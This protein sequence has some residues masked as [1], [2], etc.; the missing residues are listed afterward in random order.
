MADKAQSTDV[1][2]AVLIV[3]AGIGGMG[4]AMLLAEMGYK[5]YLLDRAPGIGGSMHLLDRTFPTDSCGLC[6]MAPVQ[7]AYCPTLECDLHPHIEILPYADLERLEGEPGAFQATIHHWPRYVDVERCNRCGQC[8][9]VCPV[10]RPSEYEEELHLEKAIYRPPSRAVPDAFVIDKTY[11]TECGRCVEVCPTEAIDLNNERSLLEGRR[12]QIEV[13]AVILSPGFTPFDARLKGE[14]GYGLY[15]NVLTSIQFERMISPAGYTQAHIVRP[16]DGTPP[17]RMAFIQCVG[18]RDNRRPEAGRLCGQ[19]YCSAVCCMYTAKQVGVAKELRPDL[20]ITVFYIDIRTFG[21]DFERYFN[22][23]AALPGVTYRR[24]MV[25]SVKQLVGSG[26]LRLTYVAE[27][28]NLRE[29]DFDMVVLAVG[30]APPTG[31][32]ELGRHLGVELNEYGFCLAHSF[33]PNHTS[34]PGVFVGGSFR[35][36]KDIPETVIEAAGAS[37]SA[38]RFLSARDGR[39]LRPPAPEEKKEQDVSEEEPRIGVFVCACGQ[40]ADQV[41]DV[42]AVAAQAQ[43]LPGVAFSRVVA[44]ACEPEGLKQIEMAIKESELNRVVVAACSPRLYR[45][46]FE[47]VM[48]EA[49]LNPYLLERVNIREQCAWVHQEDHKAATVKAEDLVAMAV[50]T[51]GFNRALQPAHITPTRS[52][53]VIGGGLAGMTAALHLAEQGCHVHLVEREAEL[54]GT[55]RRVRYVLEGERTDTFLQNL[56]AQVEGSELISVYKRAEVQEVKGYKGQYQSVVALADGEIKQL[57]HGAII[58][59]TGGQE[60]KTEEY[61][62]GREPRVVTQLELE[63]M[64]SAS[65]E[66]QTKIDSLRSVVMIQ[67]VGSRDEERPYCSRV[68]CSQAIKNALKIKELNPQVNVFILHRDVCTYGFRELYYQQARDAGVIFIRYEPT[69]KP[70]VT[71]GQVPGTLEVPGTLQVAVTDPMVGRDLTLEADL[72]VLSTGIAPHDNQ[73]LAKV[74]DVPLDEDGFFQEEHNKVRPLDSTRAGIYLCGL[75]H[76]P[77]FIDETICQASGAAS[78]AVALLSQPR[79]EDKGLVVAV[80]ERRCSGCGLCISVCP[81]RAREMDEEKHVARVVE[82]LCQ[83]CGICMAACPNKACSL[84]NLTTDQVMA[85]LEAVL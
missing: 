59:A 43:T 24:S 18:S 58:V 31:F 4:S 15:D 54:G 10:P 21:Q 67:C 20:D 66:Q 38:A 35:E 29:E 5:V 34:R 1:S 61:L 76:S 57:E 64:L 19:G 36:P 22:R 28:G 8:A 73:A 83:G 56:I 11:C 77:R 42:E 46:R 63:E 80:N 30:F 50:T 39:P 27:S 69:N 65:G 23:V 2:K 85:M 49:E 72:L 68:C 48:R 45:A 40:D 84:Q 79:L 53:L 14:Y 51:A 75:A 74:L 52:A 12:S 17:R 6:I 9:L 41:V 26:D 32:Q 25:S 60:A 7:P 71:P 55:L 47:G 16:S 70:K 13:G 62:Y 82:L 44:D 37:A 33:A 81:Y 78:R 3:G